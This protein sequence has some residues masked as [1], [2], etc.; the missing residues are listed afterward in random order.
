MKDYERVR[1]D[2][3]NAQSRLDDLAAREKALMADKM[4]FAAEKAK[5]KA[6][7]EAFGAGASAL[8]GRIA[9]EQ[10]RLEKLKADA[11]EEPLPAPPGSDAA[12]TSGESDPSK[13]PEP[14]LELEDQE[15]PEETPAEVG[16][17]LRLKHPITSDQAEFPTGE[18]PHPPTVAPPVAAGLD[19]E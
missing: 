18:L 17:R 19:E 12:S 11:E 6:D 16:E 4:A 10:D 15:Q 13:L 3:I 14:P 7:K 8:M 1:N 5:F 9:V 2:A